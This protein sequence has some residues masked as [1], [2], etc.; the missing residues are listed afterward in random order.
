VTI[1]E[2]IEAVLAEQSAANVVFDARLATLRQS[3]TSE[4][5][6]ARAQV[7]K[8]ESLLG[9]KPVQAVQH[10]PRIDREQPGDFDN[11]DEPNDE[12]SAKSIT[13]ELK[14]LRARNV[15]RRRTRA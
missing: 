1:A 4:L 6:I 12:R 3:A 13:D 10:S 2:Q 14:E 8:L 7:E 5:A 9:A 15:E 11:G